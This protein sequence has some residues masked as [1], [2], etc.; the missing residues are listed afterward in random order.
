MISAL[1]RAVEEVF[2]APL[3][4]VVAISL[5]LAAASFAGLCV[6]VAIALHNAALVGWWPVDSLIEVL[7]VLA[8]L[9]LAWLLFPAVVTIVM[10]FFLDRVAAAVESRDYPALVPPHGAGIGDI[11]A[12]TLRLMLLGVILNLLALPL[13]L[14]LPGINFF[15]FLVL[16]GYLFGRAYFEV[17]ALRRLDRGTA[18]AVRQRFAGRVF[19]GGL[20]ITGLFSLPLVNLVA[21]V[22]ATAFMVHVFEGLRRIEPR[23]SLS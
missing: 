16:N 15:V 7:G 21:P 6:A 2:T 3:R 4:R 13:Y 23:I 20:V 5:A 22:I 18:K 14:L 1:L 19:I 8:V 12:A 11:I 10:G 17:V 9:V